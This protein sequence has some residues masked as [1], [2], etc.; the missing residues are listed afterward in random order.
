VYFEEA[1]QFEVDEPGEEDLHRLPAQQQR[2]EHGCGFFPRVP[3]PAWVC[4]C[5]SHGMS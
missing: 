1:S 3:D 5:P 2:R 4:R